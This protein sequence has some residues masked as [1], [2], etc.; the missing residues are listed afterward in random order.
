MGK[1]IQ[2]QVQDALWYL[3]KEGTSQDDEDKAVEILSSIAWPKLNEAARGDELKK[4]EQSTPAVTE[5]KEFRKYV[6]DVQI[7]V[8]LGHE[9]NGGAKGE[10][11][12]NKKVAEWVVSRLEL[13]GA[14][15]FYYEHKTR[16][17]GKRQ[18]EMRAAVKAAQ[19]NN[20]VTIELHYDAVSYPQPHGH[21]FQYRGSKQLAECF[22]NRWQARFPQ[23]NPR[24]DR[25]TGI[26]YNP[27]GNGAGFLQKAV[28]WACLV[29]PFFRSNPRE[30]EFYKDK[31]KDVAG[32]YILAIADFCKLNYTR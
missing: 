11:E 20:F 28:G 32:C 8:V 14:S 29:E 10:R 6:K 18:D 16:S 24:G 25:K 3:R 19:P 4:I 7:A 21:H 23:S 17:Y 27:K 2:Q 12:Y 1:T 30:W 31:H 15:V 9:P 5:Y 26:K 22:R 13:M